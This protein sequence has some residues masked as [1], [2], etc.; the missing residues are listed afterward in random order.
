MG[1]TTDIRDQVREKLK[2]LK[3]RFHVGSAGVEAMNIACGRSD[4]LMH[5]K[6][7]Y[8]DS[9]PVVMVLDAMGYHVRLGPSGSALSRQGIRAYCWP[10]QH[11]WSGNSWQISSGLHRCALENYLRSSI[12][13]ASHN[14]SIRSNPASSIG[15]FSLASACSI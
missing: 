12:F 4:Y 1:F 10:R 6:L 11:R 14:L 15:M 3:G 2:T 13:A 9:V 7:T 5:S 8:W